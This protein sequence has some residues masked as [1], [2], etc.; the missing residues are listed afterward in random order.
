MRNA[1]LQ[2]VKT[3]Q[4]NGFE[5]YFVGGCVRDGLL[6]REIKD[7]DIATNATVEQIS[8]LFESG[9]KVGEHFGVFLAK[10]DGF[11]FEIA[12][13]RKDGE[14]LDGRRPS[15]VSTGTLLEDAERRD[16]TMNA[17]YQNPISGSIIDFFDGVDD[18]NKKV[19]RCVGDPDKRFK[20]DGLRILR[21]IRLSTSLFFDIEENTLKSAVKNA[22]ILRSISKERV[23]HELRRTFSNLDHGR[24]IDKGFLTKILLNKSILSNLIKCEDIEA[25]SVLL[26][27]LIKKGGS[28]E[29]YVAALI[30]GNENPYED[31]LAA[32]F[33]KK[34][35]KDISFVVSFAQEIGSL[36][37][38]PKHE[39]SKLFF[40]P[41]FE[42]VL[43][44]CS[45]MGNHCRNID[46]LNRVM[47]I[48]DHVWG[49][50]L[51]LAKLKI[52]NGNIVG[53]IP[54]YSIDFLM[55]LGYSGESLGLKYQELY[56]FQLAK[57]IHEK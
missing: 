46:E 48:K 29:E 38:Y 53:L 50:N 2:I 18:I 32:K 17:I 31:L 24:Y 20:E 13:F 57:L 1:A 28:F 51:G 9:V 33:P 12:T 56:N 47:Y 22:D 3:L 23:Y 45:L 26:G 44:L 54:E 37:K 40:D 6:K 4:Q 35:A 21:A 55:E 10:V 27:N 7:Y 52:E 39:I 8:P 5:A 19:I 14:Y 36:T 15:S 41:R 11:S 42:S 43:K 30:I 25:T 49:K 34:E 16:F